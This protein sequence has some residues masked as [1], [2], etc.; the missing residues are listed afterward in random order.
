MDLKFLAVSEIAPLHDMV[1]C[2]G[3]RHFVV[4]SDCCLNI[5]IHDI[6]LS[7]YRTMHCLK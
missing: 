6:V 5:G 4:M 2:M 7:V 3:L 1:H